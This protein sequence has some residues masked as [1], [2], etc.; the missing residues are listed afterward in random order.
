MKK[1]V[2]LV[3]ALIGF[4]FTTV[5]QNDTIVT[6]AG[7]IAIELDAT[8]IDIDV[9]DA[10]TTVTCQTLDIHTV[11]DIKLAIG[12]MIKDRKHLSF[13]TYWVFNERE[14]KKESYYSISIRV[15]EDILLVG[16][17]EAENLLIFH[18]ATKK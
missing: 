3:I 18:Q 14:D 1:Y 13:A 5:P 12:K 9:A 11:D 6:L 10:L 17:W 8:V 15:F 4:S 7:R 16:Y 2:L